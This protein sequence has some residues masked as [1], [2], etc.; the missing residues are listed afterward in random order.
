MS[1]TW[2][3]EDVTESR[4][5]RALCWVADYGIPSTLAAVC[6]ACALAGWFVHPLLGVWT[7][8]VFGTLAWMFVWVMAQ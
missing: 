5:D 4:F 2:N 6:A 8:L 1:P 7:T 3:V